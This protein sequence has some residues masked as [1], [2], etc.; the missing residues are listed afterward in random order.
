MNRFVFL[1]FLVGTQLFAQKQFAPISAV[2]NYEGHEFYCD[3]NH[4]QY[5][6]EQEVEI[7]DKDCSIIYSYSSSDIDTT[8]RKSN[9]SLIVWEDEN[10][11]YF[12]EDNSFYLL[13]DFNAEVGDTVIFFDPIN[14]EHFSSIYNEQPS[15]GPI[16]LKF[17]VSNIEEKL[18]SNQIRKFFSVNYIQELYYECFDQALIIENIGSS[19]QKLVGDCLIYVEF[20]ANCYDNSTEHDVEIIGQDGKV[21]LNQGGFNLAAGNCFSKNNIPEIQNESGVEL[22]YWVTADDLS[23]PG[24]CRLGENSLNIMQPQSTLNP[25]LNCG[26]GNI[27]LTSGSCDELQITSFDQGIDLLSKIDRQIEELSRSSSS[28][29]IANLT[30]IKNKVLLNQLGLFYD[31]FDGENFN[32]DIASFLSSRSEFFVSAQLVEAYFDNNNIQKAKEQLRSIKINNVEEENYLKV[33]E[34]YYEF[35]Y[36]KHYPSSD[37]LDFLKNVGISQKSINGFARSVYYIIT[38]ER[39]KLERPKNDVRQREKDI[40]NESFREVKIFPNP[41]QDK[42][43]ITVLENR[44]IESYKVDIFDLSGNKLN[45]QTIESNQ[46]IEFDTSILSPGLYIVKIMSASGELIALEKI[47]LVK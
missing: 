17:I 25:T 21:F 38:G 41:V 29:E 32:R 10:R 7:D 37:K 30:V 6:V 24:S 31:S 42:F 40:K 20:L 45:G 46:Q 23:T 43:H 14:K 1:F 22:N 5:R 44:N 34:I 18:I 13:F 33:Q 35:V 27:F 36:K 2:W 12:F 4:I 39:I 47:S 3:G 19:S 28:A 16:E 15:N 11:I 26:Y 9:D 8:F